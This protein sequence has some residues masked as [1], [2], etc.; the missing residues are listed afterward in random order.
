MGAILPF[1]EV[2]ETSK[3]MS[4]T[5]VLYIPGPHEPRHDLNTFLEPMVNDLL[6]LWN[7]V[8]LCVAAVNCRKQ[9]RCVLLCVACDLPAGRKVCGFLGHNVHLG[10]S[11]CYDF[12]EQ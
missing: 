7:G 9:I 2:F 8:V 11:R 1:Q 6:K 5:L 12:L 10:C 4:F 3:R